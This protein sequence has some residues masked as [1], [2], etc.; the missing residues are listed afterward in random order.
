MKNEKIGDSVISLFNYVKILK[1]INDR[2]K[3]GR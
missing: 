1:K 2:G 3:V